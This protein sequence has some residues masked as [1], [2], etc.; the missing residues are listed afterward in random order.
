MDDP[1]GDM[2]PAKAVAIVLGG[3]LVF[4]AFVAFVLTM[5]GVQ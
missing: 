2:H 4:W 5:G 3:C 1:G